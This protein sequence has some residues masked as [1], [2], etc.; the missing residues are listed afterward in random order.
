MLKHFAFFKI[1]LFSFFI[2]LLQFAQAQNC[3]SG[4]INVEPVEQLVGT[5]GLLQLK[6]DAEFSTGQ[7]CIDQIMDGSVNTHTGNAP[8]VVLNVDFLLVDT[9]DPT[10]VITLADDVDLTYLGG[11][12]EYWAPAHGQLEYANCDIDGTYTLEL[13]LNSIQEVNIEHYHHGWCGVELKF[14][15]GAPPVVLN[16]LEVGNTFVL[17]EETAAPF[18]VNYE[19]CGIT[20]VKGRQVTEACY[21]TNGCGP[22]TVVGI[23]GPSDITVVTPPSLICAPTGTTITVVDQET[24]CNRTFVAQCQTGKRD[25][26]EESGAI[27]VAY[28]NPFNDYINLSLED[29][30]TLYD[31]TLYN[32]LGEEIDVFRMEGRTVDYDTSALAPGIY[33]LTMVKDGM[34]VRTVKL[35]KI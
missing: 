20:T 10:N 22:Y 24:G 29:V 28:P 2:L 8:Y 18:R 23:G 17:D 35:S 11:W 31:F 32:H 1:L 30:E 15:S 27:P 21:S 25:L 34:V 14:V 4:S 19:S 33:Y 5:C 3:C 13:L 26:T 12:T 9:S 7:I 16:G 6:F